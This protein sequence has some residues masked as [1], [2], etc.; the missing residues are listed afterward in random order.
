[1]EV[2]HTPNPPSSIIPTNIAGEA[3][4]WKDI[5]RWAGIIGPI[6]AF[7]FWGGVQL[8]EI[9]NAQRIMQRD[10]T[11]IKA[12]VKA[13]AT[14]EGHPKLERRVLLLEHKAHP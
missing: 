2:T 3:V 8:N 10:I 7:A 6:A 5:L 14:T 11:E 4:T 1:M 13:H 12:S 9:S